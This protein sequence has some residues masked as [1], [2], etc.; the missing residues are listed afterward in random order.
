MADSGKTASYAIRVDS[1]A[2]DI[3]QEGA[4]ALEQLRSSI[5]K[6]QSAIKEI[7]G[8]LRNLRGNSDEVAKA[9]TELKAQLEAERGAVS[10]ATLALAKM[11]T[12]FGLLTEREKKFAKEQTELT[13]KL[14]DAKTA[15]AETTKGASSM[16]SEMAKAG[17]P[18]GELAKRGED[19]GEKL[20]TGAG[21]FGLIAAAAAVT[22]GALVEVGKTIADLTVSLVKWIVTSANAARTANLLRVAWTGSEANAKALGHQI[23]ALAT[24]V[25]I[26]KDKLNEM[27]GALVRSLSG[28]RVSG[29]AIVDLLSTVAQTSAAM[30]DEAAHKLQDIIERAK[31]LGRIQISPFELQGTGLARDDIA[32]EL[33]A[34]MKVGVESARAALAS[35][36][37]KIEDG[38]K[39]IR[40]AVEKRFGKVNL[41]RML[42]LDVLKQKFQETLAALTKDVNLEPLLK[43][44]QQ[45][46]KLFDQSTVS[47]HILKTLVTTIGNELGPAFQKV[48]PIAREFFIRLEIGALKI[49]IALVK[50][51]NEISKSL[52]GMGKDFDSAQAK[53]VAWEYAVNRPIEHTVAFIRTMARW[54]EKAISMW[55]T[56][57]SEVDS[58]KKSFTGFE[59]LGYNAITGLIDGVTSGIAALKQTISGLADTIK[60]AFRDALGIHSPSKVFEGYGKDTAKGY[61]R[62]LDAGGQGVSTSASGLAPASPSSAPLS[63][64]PA[65]VGGTGRPSVQVVV[66]LNVAAGAGPGAPQA[67][68]MLTEP[69]FLQGLTKAVEDALVGA[70]IPVQAPAGSVP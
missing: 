39:A 52:D 38:A 53:A 57:S 34:Q 24:K 55:R 16:L 61:E 66:N 37:V 30:G 40:A 65:A 15:E 10:A 70:A 59:Q 69:G 18:L 62:G 64:S 49:A 50:A 35:G 5:G 26:A 48:V 54:L 3:G 13:K 1:N 12:T 32:K 41:A 22:V 63:P 47:G 4:A 33:A 21:A 19:L 9:K 29:Q 58:A 17:G 8:A 23:D 67:V 60:S 27:A 42:D 20:S 28:T 2:K 43:G 7:G 36:R 68:A 14:K 51:R 25:P 6:S 11:G 46:T 31:N 45:L 44:F 56:L